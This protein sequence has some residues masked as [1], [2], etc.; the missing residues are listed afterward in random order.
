MMTTT[1][2]KEDGDDSKGDTTNRPIH[3]VIIHLDLGIGGAEQLILQLAQASVVGNNYVIDIVTSRCDPDHC[4]AS[5]KP[6]T[7]Q[8]YNNLHVWGQWLPHHLIAGKYGKAICST[9][10]LLYLTFCV[11]RCRRWSDPSSKPIP[12]VIVLDVLPTPL[13][14][15][16]YLLPQ[17]ST[18]FYCHY[19]DQLLVQNINNPNTATPRHRRSLYR[20]LLD[21]I[22]EQSMVYSDLTVV[23]SNFTRQT[24]LQTFPTLQNTN[25]PIPVVY[26]ALDISS[27]TTTSTST[28]SL[29]YD[30]KIQRNKKL[31]ISLI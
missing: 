16:Q 20:R 7:G 1:T 23:N 31:I 4:F 21:W 29:L 26:P 14:I 15:L 2:P 8:F 30:I 22:E 6:G 19:P 5:V 27:S 9:I 13:P 18:L 10:R 17:S 12:D 25:R 11:V 28:S 24:V 3:I